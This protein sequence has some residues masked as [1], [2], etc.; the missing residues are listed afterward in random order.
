MSDQNRVFR[1]KAGVLGQQL[2][3]DILQDHRVS[4]L[5]M[6]AL[7]LLITIRARQ[8]TGLPI[9]ANPIH[10]SRILSLKDKEFQKLMEEL[11][12]H[13]VPLV[14]EDAAGFLAIQPFG[15][16]V[17]SQTAAQRSHSARMRWERDRTG[18]MQMQQE[19]DQLRTAATTKTGRKRKD[20]VANPGQSEAEEVTPATGLGSVTSV[21]QVP[22]NQQL[23]LLGH[24]LDPAAAKK[25][26]RT[27]VPYSQFESLFNTHC[28]SLP[29]V[30]AC[31]TWNT[32]RNAAVRSRWNE[33]PEIEFWVGFFQ[34]VERT[35]FLTGRGK[36]QFRA[37]FDWIMGPK[38]FSKIMEGNY[39]PI[40][41]R[42]TAEFSGS[43]GSVGS[44]NG[45][46]SH[47]IDEQASWL[48]DRS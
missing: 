28:S 17:S 11:T 37:S 6:A 16:L 22:P 35:D 12:S 3:Q 21:N 10:A 19:I 45:Y 34:R 5:S 24:D 46:G 30:H 43:G 13:S 38:N 41:N 47:E 40:G 39:D 15:K 48:Q 29:S 18:R 7:G 9:S 14:T 42:R 25:A 23:D 8:D 26:Q 36:Q 44:V 33:H 2:A 1:A 20:S 27:N 32:S 4:T 31:S